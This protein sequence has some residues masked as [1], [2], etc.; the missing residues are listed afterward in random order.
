MDVLCCIPTARKEE[1]KLNMRWHRYLVTAFVVVM[2]ALLLAACGSQ[3]TASGVAS[4]Q[5]A[6]GARLTVDRNSLNFGNVAYEKWIRASFKVTNSGN[7]P[8]VLTAP[9]SVRAVEGC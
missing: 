3:S 8:L 6:A 7:A 4:Q 2:A 5:P 1:A 9:P